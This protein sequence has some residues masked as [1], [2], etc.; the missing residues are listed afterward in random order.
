ML[1]LTQQSVVSRR[2]GSGFLLLPLFKVSKLLS[3]ASLLMQKTTTLLGTI[4]TGRMWG[5]GK[6]PF[7]QQFY[8]NIPEGQALP[9]SPPVTP[10]HM[11]DPKLITA[12]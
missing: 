4:Y 10:N 5:G 11:T 2:P 12:Y 9:A 3:I 1:P 8:L 6:D 7:L